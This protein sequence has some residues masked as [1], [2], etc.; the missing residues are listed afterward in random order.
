MPSRLCVV[1]TDWTENPRTAIHALVATIATIMTD[2]IVRHFIETLLSSYNTMYSKRL[3]FFVK[4]LMS[5]SSSS[6][7]ICDKSFSKKVRDKLG[8][9]S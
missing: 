7:L 9:P 4:D 2:T 6:V 1:C 8:R 5:M 3:L